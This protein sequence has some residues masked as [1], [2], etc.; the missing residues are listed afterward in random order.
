MMTSGSITPWQ[1]DGE[2]METVTDFIFFYSKITADDDCSHKMKTL[3]YG[4]TNTAL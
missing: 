3:M 2:S 4:K 1:I